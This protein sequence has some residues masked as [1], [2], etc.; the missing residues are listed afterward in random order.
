[1]TTGGR[2]A[3]AL[4]AATALLAV[5]LPSSTGGV[6]SARLGGAGLSLT[7]V[8]LAG[9]LVRQ[10]GV[11]Q[12][13]QAVLAGTTVASLVLATLFGPFDVISP[14]LIPIFGSIAV[15]VA[16]DLRDLALVGVARGALLLVLGVSL[17]FGT[18]LAL[19]MAWADRLAVGWYNAFYVDL[20]P[21]MVIRFD[22]P[23]LTFATHSLAAFV[24]YLFV[25]LCYTAWRVR[26]SLLAAMGTLWFLFLLWRLSSTT[27]LVLTGVALLQILALLLRRHRWLV[28]V[29]TVVLIGTTICGL[30]LSGLSAPQMLEIVR[31]AILGN[32]ANG[33]ISRYASGGLLAG[34]F[35]YLSEH[36]LQP[37]G[38]GFSPTLYLGDSG[39]VLLLMRGSVPL[40]LAVY[41]GLFAFLHYNLRSRA[42]ATWIFIVTVAFEVGFTPLQYYRFVGLL[43]LLVVGFNAALTPARPAA[44]RERYTWTLPAR[45]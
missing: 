28:P 29:L 45:S 37:I 44:G 23:V 15:L 12:P 43:P 33:L 1:M 35:R 17:V 13:V 24:M 30:L 4:L 7:T 31:D 3:R 18:G 32:R 6:I 2:A 19:D 38:L 14:G 8:L 22:K 25:Y 34:N 39:V 21:N 26:Q 41:G 36:P 16:L 9:L 10:H 27:S 11:G 5:Y 42:V 20:L 40:M